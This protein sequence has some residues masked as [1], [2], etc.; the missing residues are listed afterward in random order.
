MGQTGKRGLIGKHDNF[1][2]LSKLKVQTV[3]YQTNT[4]I[5]F[6]CFES[7]K[8]WHPVNPGLDIQFF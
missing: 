6:R 5:E 2:N 8:S 3:Q 1:S 7:R 4:V